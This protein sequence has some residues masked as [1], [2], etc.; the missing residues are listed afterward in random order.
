MTCHPVSAMVEASRRSNSRL[1]SPSTTSSEEG[2]G[3]SKHAATVA[4]II[5]NCGAIAGGLIAGY[6]SQYLGRR[7]TV[8]VCCVWTCC[9][10][11]L[12]LLPNTFPGLAAG[13]FFLQ[14]GVQGAWSVVPVWLSEISPQA[15]RTTWPGVVSKLRFGAR[16]IAKLTCLRSS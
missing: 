10:L 12:W 7:L 15:F 2:K 5:G 6:V 4:T 1:T 8:I 14:M 16:M 11:P 13:A 9:F 3:L